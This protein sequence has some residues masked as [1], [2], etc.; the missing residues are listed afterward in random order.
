MTDTAEYISYVPKME[1]VAF[2]S[3]TNVVVNLGDKTPNSMTVNVT[4]PMLEQMR[5]PVF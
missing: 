2:D 5:L 1:L 4:M 3:V